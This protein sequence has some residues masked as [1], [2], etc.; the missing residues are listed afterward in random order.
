MAIRICSP[1][2]KKVK[3][4]LYKIYFNPMLQCF[5]RN[6]REYKIPYCIMSRKFG[7]CEEGPNNQW[8]PDCD[9]LND[10]DLLKL[11]KKQAKKYKGVTFIYWFHRP[12]HKKWIKMLKNAG[13]NIRTERRMKD[14]EKYRSN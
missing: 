8:Y 11:L 12:T 4:Y 5:F 3:N 2:K 10:E 14:Y 7:I 9:M 1:Q 6:L 13:F